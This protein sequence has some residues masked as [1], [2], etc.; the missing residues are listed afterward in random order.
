[1]NSSHF[2]TRKGKTQ[3]CTSINLI[4]DILV[5]FFTLV[6]CTLLRLDNGEVNYEGSIVSFHFIDKYSVDTM[7]S[8]SCDDGY[9]LTGPS[10]SICQ[11]SGTWDPEIPTCGNEMNQNILFR[12]NCLV[13]SAS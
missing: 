5:I 7:A 9:S 6:A 10:S 4:Q 13:Y 1:M 3:L 11:D 2:K 8:F 12:L